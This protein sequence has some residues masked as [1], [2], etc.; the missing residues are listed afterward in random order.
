MLFALS[1][2]CS[3]DDESGV[4][5]QEEETQDV[6]PLNDDELSTALIRIAQ[7]NAVTDE[8][9]LTNLGDETSEIGSY[10]MCLGP[11]TY[12]QVSSLTEESTNLE[13]NESVT[14]SYDMNP[15]ADGLSVFTTNTFDSV[16]PTVLLDYV[17][18]GAGNQP[19]VD[20]AVT[21]GRWDDAASYVI[22]GSPY[23]FTGDASDFGSAFWEGTEVL[24]GVLRI[25]NV[26][27]DTDQV[28]LTNLGGASIDVGDY[29]LCLG[30][31]TY[32][33][34]SSVASGST[35]LAPEETITL[36]YDMNPIQDGLSIF[37]TNSFSSSDPTVLLDYV[38]WGAGNQAR[39]GQAVAAGRWGDVNNFVEE[40][41]PYNFTGNAE[42]V[43][44]TFWE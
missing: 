24:E 9:V 2:G 36:D 38:Q 35:M 23:V 4:T 13:P 20:Q 31:G 15:T 26:D 25:L 40:G 16:D 22:N 11:G 7:V 17:Q 6:P 3:S 29:F 32:Q 1:I 39:V 41:S 43:G 28:T 27:T 19:R 37:S 5:T 12:A 8:V 21:A 44:V 10:F 42:E 18:W 34:I 14:L 30:P 33:Q